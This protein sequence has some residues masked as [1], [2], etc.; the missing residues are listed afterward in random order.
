MPTFSVVDAS[1]VP[2]GP[3]VSKSTAM[4]ASKPGKGGRSTRGDGVSAVRA[5]ARNAAQLGI[6]PSLP[7]RPPADATTRAALES[8]ANSP[9]ARQCRELEA[10]IANLEAER[11]KGFAFL[12]GRATNGGKGKQRREVFGVAP[13]KAELRAINESIASARVQL[14]SLNIRRQIAFRKA[15]EAVGPPVSLPLAWSVLPPGGW[16]E[17][18]VA[19][20]G[21]RVESPHRRFEPQRIRLLDALQ[22]NEWYSGSHLGEMVYLVAVFDTVAVADSPDWGNAL[23]YYPVNQGGWR[24]VF[25]LEKQRALAAGARRIIH[26]EGWEERVRR[27]AAGS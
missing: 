11:R 24:N 18:V 26:T 16:R 19:P 7:N 6:A 27:L 1:Q 12:D 10:S 8:V 2:K 21:V 14:A 17:F 13:L 23:Y 25:R 4:I 22:P 9:L 20:P 5:L 15:L 3:R